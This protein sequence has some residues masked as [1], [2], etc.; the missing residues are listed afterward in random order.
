M[1][2]SKGKFIV[3]EGTDGSGTTSQ[4]S[5]LCDALVKR[6][7]SCVK[8]REPSQG[9]VGQLLR[10]ALE[11]RLIRVDN[12]QGFDW[13]TLALLFAADRMDHLQNE[14]L[15][16]LTKGHWV[17]SDRYTLS[18]LI[19]QSITAPEEEAGLAWVK[20]LNRNA[21]QPD[22]VI[23]LDVSPEIAESRRRAR[24]GA[25]ELFDRR[26]LQAQLAKAYISAA[27]YSTETLLHIDGAASM[28]A[29]AEQII[30]GVCRKFLR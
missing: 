23:V 29:V 22:L 20:E 14:V 12:G 30:Q 17:I 3:L 5:L 24:G 21:L 4:S 1:Q 9:P 26:E 2:P 6:G 28:D 18:S 25:E 8:T 27:R 10:S 16:A 19:Y 15:P 7:I 11:K 13:A